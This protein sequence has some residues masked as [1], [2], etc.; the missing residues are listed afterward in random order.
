MSD[1]FPGNFAAA[2]IGI[3]W[4][5]EDCKIGNVSASETLQNI[6][7]T[8]SRAG[9]H[10]TVS[11]RAYGD[12]SGLE[13]PS[14]GIK[15]NH[16]PAGERYA[17]HTKILED[18][19]SWSGEHPE[20][21]NLMLI[22]KDNI[23][24]DLIEIVELLKSRKKYM[25]HLVK[26]DLHYS[27]KEIAASQSNSLSRSLRLKTMVVMLCNGKTTVC[28][29]FENCWNSTGFDNSPS[30]TK[31]QFSLLLIP[32]QPY[33]LSLRSK[34]AAETGVF[35]DIEDCEIP[36]DLSAGYVLEK[37]RSNLSSSGHHGTVSI[38]AYGDMTGHQFP[39][40]G[41]KLNHFPAGERYARHTKMLEDIVSW[42]AE[43]PE[44][45]TLML[46]MGDDAS[47]D[48]IDVVKLLKSR[49]NYR[50]LFAHA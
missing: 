47:D 3:F 50:L 25:F 44:P 39:S 31:R 36:D 42:A 5:L 21:S 49:K 27:L 2:E 19:V 40:E 48:F 28:W 1:V 32:V 26:A 16:F 46:I 24:D 22:M 35:W 17:R 23:S 43:H 13:F 15:L 20:P 11:I 4:D 12:M 38:R 45:S 37:I 7:L 6:K 34:K 41:I 9:H 10:G 14:D 8:I 18:I 33:N 29:G 30:P